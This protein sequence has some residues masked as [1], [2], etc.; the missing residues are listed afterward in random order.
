MRPTRRFRSTLLASALAVCATVMAVRPASAQDSTD[1]EIRG[2]ADAV[3]VADDARYVWNDAVRLA[4]FKE[5]A[6]PFVVEAVGLAGAT[7]L[8]KVALARVLVQLKER[9]RAADTLLGV[10]ASDAPVALRVEA[11]RLLGETADDAGAREDELWALLDEALDPRLRAALAKTLWLATKDLDAKKRLGELL[12]SDDFDIRVEGAMALAEIGDF[13]DHVKAVLQQIRDEPTDRGRL[14][15]TLLAK[16]EWIRISDIAGGDD[17]PAPEVTAPPPATTLEALIHDTLTRV[18]AKYVEPE[19]IELQKLYEGAARGLVAAIG[20][21][22]TTF[23]SA[24]ERDDWQ[25]HLTKEYGGIGAYVGYDKEGFFI[26]TRPMFGSPAWKNG[27]RSGDRVM[28]VDGWE[29]SGEE[30]TEIV[31]HLRGPADSDVVVEIVRRGWTE[32]RKVTLT[33]GFIVVPTVRAE[34]LP[35]GVGYVL[36]ETFAKNTAEE[37]RDALRDLERRGATSLVLDLRWNSGGYLRTAEQMADYLLPAGRLV[38]ETAGR[39]GVHPD[40]TY[41]SKGTSSAWSRSVPMRVLVN[42]ASASASEILS[43]CL[44]VHERAQIVGLR[45]YGKGSVQNLYPI[46]TQPFAE[47]FTDL[48][49]NSQ[50]D[51]AEPFEDLNENGRRDANERYHDADR[52]KRW[53]PAEPYT[54]SNGNGHY[55][56]PAVKVTIAKYFVGSR[57]GGR[58][59]NPHRNEMVVAGR[60][61]WLGG[62]EPD[63][64]VESDEIDGWRAEAIAELD[65]DDVFKKYVDEAFA[66]HRETMMRLAVRDSRRP[67]DYPGFD[68]FYAALDTQLSQEDVWQWLHTQVR[69]RASDELGRLLVGDW[70]IDAQ[71]QRA[72][73]D[74]MEDVPS[75]AATPDFAFVA[76]RTFEIPAAYTKDALEKARPVR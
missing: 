46:F 41:I 58:Q 3:A 24:D 60:R 27:L 25:D 72:I 28:T 2:L 76:A 71:M 38:V 13:G 59:I 7:P 70:A 68:V 31:K 52:N 1:E 26:I 64:P 12:R 53:T 48:N 74:L 39:P 4:S 75:L 18:R 15:D 40:E 30:L 56:C 36:V 19:K 23:Q 43:G 55:D 69:A 44:K 42:G 66:A 62:I 21:P 35:G 17:L 22:H 49:R 47:P 54:D 11:I 73:A 45:T 34:L 8:G 57:P 32:P 61:E 65:Q 10:A 33:R 63:L 5:Q 14:A 51:D 6:T 67:E 29:T 9:S 37:F 20:D 16:D 50:W